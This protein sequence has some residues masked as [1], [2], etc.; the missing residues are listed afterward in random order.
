MR[1]TATSTTLPSFPPRNFPHKDAQRIRDLS[2]QPPPPLF[3][4]LFLIE[5]KRTTG[6][7]VP[8]PDL[9]DQ[10]PLFFSS[11]RFFNYLTDSMD[12]FFLF[13]SPN[14]QKTFVKDFSCTY[15]RKNKLKKNKKKI[16]GQV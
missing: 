9:K 15:L 8:T 16:C 12:G 3:S 5:K 4:P 13:L 2:S 7:S 1:Q 10:S 11:L 6:L 14:L